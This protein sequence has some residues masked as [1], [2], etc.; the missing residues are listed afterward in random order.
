MSPDL[1]NRKFQTLVTGIVEVLVE[2]MRV[3]AWTKIDMGAICYVI[4]Y[5]KKKYS[6][7]L[8]DPGLNNNPP[9]EKWKIAM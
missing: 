5:N 7:R 9:S 6:L 8:I 4:D 3:H 1:L 2:D